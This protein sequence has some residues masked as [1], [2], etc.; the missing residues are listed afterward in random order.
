[1]D[2]LIKMDDIPL[3]VYYVCSGLTFALHSTYKYHANAIDYM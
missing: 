3:F 2:F 1:M